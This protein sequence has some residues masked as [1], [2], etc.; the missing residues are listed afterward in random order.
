MAVS[1]ISTKSTAMMAILGL[2]VGGTMEFSSRYEEDQFYAVPPSCPPGFIREHST[3][4]CNC[5]AGTSSGYYGISKCD[6]DLHQS[7]VDHDYWIGYE[8]GKAESENTLLSGY[9]PKSFCSPQH[10]YLLPST[11]NIS[12]LEETVCAPHRIG[13]LCGRCQANYSARYHSLTLKCE[14]D[15][16]CEWGWVFY[17]VSEIIPV[18]IIFLLIT[19]NNVS[20]TS[21]LANSF[22]FYSQTVKMLHVR[23]GNNIKAFIVAHYLEKI[24]QFIYFF[25][26]LDP[27]VLDEIAYCITKNA[28]ALDIFSFSNITATYSF[29]LIILVV[30]ISSRFN[31]KCTTRQLQRQRRS[32]KTVVQG[33]MIHG[34]SSF[35][36]LFSSRCA[37]N[38][39]LILGRI[40]IYGEGYQKWRSVTRYNGEIGWM[41]VSHLPYAIP[42]LVVLTIVSIPPIVLIIYPIH[43]KILSIFNL[44]ETKC[45]K[46][47]F[48]PLER[49]KPFFDS[50]Q[51][52]FKDNL[53]FFSGLY[54]V[55][56]IVVSLLMATLRPADAHLSVSVLFALLLAL[57]GAAQP[58]VRRIHNIVDVLLLC[59]LLLINIITAYNASKL[60]SEETSAGISLAVS[61]TSWVQIFLIF[62]PLGILFVPLK[63]VIWKLRR[64]LEEST[65]VECSESARYGSF[66]HFHR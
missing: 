54:F 64:R 32:K 17:V 42:A 57:H 36:L 49:L 65:S 59:N 3:G 26:N 21:G 61:V 16:Y 33:N 62:M 30:L 5:S 14:A 66:S 19:L 22:L 39:I 11:A 4:K 52:C 58:Y 12:L 35:I 23:A 60:S 15:K 6:L 7:Y 46:C 63:R 10:G 41:S 29:F 18:T 50:F 20:F 38:S 2:L 53:R 24:H 47:I 28:N 9:C 44:A 27:F 37:H 1:C 55:Y 48:D 8:S 56:R 40:N 43:Y 25:L 34:L 13:V 45:A 31:L 51:G